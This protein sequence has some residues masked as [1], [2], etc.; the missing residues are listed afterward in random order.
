MHDNTGEW[1]RTRFHNVLHVFAPEMQVEEKVLEETFEIVAFDSTE[2][3]AL[4][5]FYLELIETQKNCL[6]NDSGWFSLQVC[7]NLAN[8]QRI[9]FNSFGIRIG[10]NTV[11]LTISINETS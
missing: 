7:K 1:R 5:N 4:E 9:Q 3:V 10:F 11:S 8:L 6:K 2:L